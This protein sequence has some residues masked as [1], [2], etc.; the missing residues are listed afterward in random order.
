MFS[1]HGVFQMILANYM[2]IYLIFAFVLR[3]QRK[4]ELAY[5]FCHIKM[6]WD[7]SSDAL[8]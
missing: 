4:I 3:H 6:N 7:N 5:G 2:L 8:G 1:P